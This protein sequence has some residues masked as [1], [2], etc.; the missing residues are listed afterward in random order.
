MITGDLCDEDDEEEYAANEDN[1]AHD[2]D[3]Q[4]EIEVNNSVEFITGVEKIHIE[5]KVKKP[6][7]V[8]K[9]PYLKNSQLFDVNIS[10]YRVSNKAR[11]PKK[12]KHWRASSSENINPR[13]SVSEK[14]SSRLRP[15]NRSGNASSNGLTAAT[16]SSRHMT[17]EEK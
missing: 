6:E 3:E 13:A 15:E 5:E 17:Q 10:D 11:K 12:M 9:S 4:Q 16:S 14:R 2:E 1:Y 8:E 7:D